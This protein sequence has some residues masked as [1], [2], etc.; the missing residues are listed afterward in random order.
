MEQKF[1]RPDILYKHQNTDK[2]LLT[3][4][5]SQKTDATISSAELDKALQIA[6][7]L[8]FKW[9]SKLVFNSDQIFENIFSHA[10]KYREQNSVKTRVLVDNHKHVSFSVQTF[11][12][13]SAHMYIDLNILRKHFVI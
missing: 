2:L 12:Q 9:F 7:G 11:L 3:N 10:A 1:C 4:R 13:N 6:F 5:A 8:R